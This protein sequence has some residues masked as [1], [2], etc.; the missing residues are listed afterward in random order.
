MLQEELGPFDYLLVPTIL[1]SQILDVSFLGLCFRMRA[2]AD[3]A[4][5][6]MWGFIS[7]ASALKAELFRGTHI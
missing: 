3:I 4:S 1:Q 7:P 2:G 5:L 6:E